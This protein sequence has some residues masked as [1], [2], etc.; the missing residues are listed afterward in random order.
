LGAVLKVAEIRGIRQI[1]VDGAHEIFCG[2]CVLVDSPQL[3]WQILYSAVRGQ[4]GRYLFGRVAPD[5][6]AYL[7]QSVPGQRLIVAC[8]GVLHQL[9]GQLRDFGRKS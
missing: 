9:G 7:Q 8:I 6:L 1:G 3:P 5:F 2:F 4:F